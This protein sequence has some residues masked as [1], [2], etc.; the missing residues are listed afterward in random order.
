[1][2]FRAGTLTETWW[3]SHRG[4]FCIP[5]REGIPDLEVEKRNSTGSEPEPSSPAHRELVS[6]YAPSEMAPGVLTMGPDGVPPP[7]RRTTFGW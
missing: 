6:N 7:P 5:L 3:L 2:G 1:M 4:S